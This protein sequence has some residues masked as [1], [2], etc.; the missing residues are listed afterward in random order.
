VSVG[1]A[2][3]R[4]PDDGLLADRVVGAIFALI[5]A[6]SLGDLLWRWPPRIWEGTGPG[7]AFL[8]LLL[9]VLVIGLSL[10][11]VAGR[12]KREAA[13]EADEQVPVGQ[14]VRFIALIVALIVLFPWLGGLVALGLFVFIEMV[15]IE[16]SRVLVAA[17]GLVVTLLAVE[18]IFVR[19]LAVPLPTGFFGV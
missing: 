7:P 10:I 19:V 8:P 14:T 17:I 15:W 18:A 11:L 5:G 12:A 4:R 13:D 6:A 2:D 1:Q 3:E 16:R 9:A